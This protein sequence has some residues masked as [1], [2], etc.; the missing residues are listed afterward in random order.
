MWLDL[1]LSLIV[2]VLSVGSKMYT[3]AQGIQVLSHTR[4]TSEGKKKYNESRGKEKK[5]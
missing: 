1:W 2:L 3:I 5:R 4:F